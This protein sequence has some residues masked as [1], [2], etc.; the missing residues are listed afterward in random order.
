MA[1]ASQ[2]IRWL[3]PGAK[4]RYDATKLTAPRWGEKGFAEWQEACKV[5]FDEDMARLARI[6]EWCNHVQKT[7]NNADIIRLIEEFSCG[8]ALGPMG[9]PIYDQ[10]FYNYM[11]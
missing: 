7:I 11:D 2:N 4:E 10:F 8:D 6:E 5:A 9:L 3:E 1:A